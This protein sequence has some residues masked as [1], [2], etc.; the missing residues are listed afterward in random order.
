MSGQTRPEERPHEA[1]PPEVVTALGAVPTVQQWNAISHPLS[2]C[3]VIAGAGSG[4]TAVM[5]ARLVYL[6]LVRL[7]RLEDDHDGA[8]PSEVLCLTFTNKAAEEL[9]R[10]VRDATA[11]LDLPEGEEATV[12]TYHAFASRLLDEYGLRMGLERSLRLL[13]EAQRWQLC[14]SLLDE[15]EFEHLE[16]RTDY[17]V[18]VAL[19][20]ADQCANHLRDPQEVVDLDRALVQR[21]EVER[22]TG[23]DAKLLSAAQRRMEAAALAQA[24]QDRKREIGAIDYGD[25]IRLAYDLIEKHPEVAEAFRARFPVLLLDE[26]QDTNVAQARLL[27]SLCGRGY[28]VFAVG[29]PDQNIYAW[30]GASLANLLRF[31]HD[32][33][34]PDQGRELPLYVNFRSGSRILD[35]ANLVIEPVPPERRAADKEL[36]P[37]ES[38][39]EGRVAAF[40]AEDAYAEGRRIAAIIQEEAQGT[41]TEE[42]H[43]DYSRFAILCRKSRLFEPISEVLREEGIPVEVVDLGGLLRIP[44]VVEVV[45]WLRLLEDPGYNVGFTRILTGPRWRIGYRDLAAL[46]RWSAERTR[47]LR[48]EL[49]GDDDMPGDVVFA[50]VEALDHLDDE[51]MIGLSE[52]ARGR[53]REFRGVLGRVQ[54]GAGGTLGDLLS[55]I[56]EESGLLAELESSR[57]PAAL[58]ARRNLLN[59]VQHVSSFAPVEGQATLST[60]IEYFRTA[61]EVEDDLERAQPSEA[62]TVKMLTIHKAKGLEWDVVFVPGLAEHDRYAS[63]IFPDTSR[64]ANPATQYGTMPFELR[65]DAEVLPRYEGDIRGFRDAL[66]ER[67]MEEERRLCYVAFTRA[68]QL[69]VASAAHWYP[70]PREPHRPGTFHEHVASYAMTEVLG[71]A[72]PPGESPLVELRRRRAGDWPQPARSDDGDGLL[73]EGWHEAA[74]AAV[75]DP[76]WADR[77]A[78]ALGPGDRRTFERRVAADT[79]RAALIRRQTEVRDV[80]AL[81]SSLSVSSV[82]DYLRCPKLFYW[83]QVR[84]LPRRPSQAARL[85]T[86]VHRWI[87]IQSKGQLALLDVDAL[88]DLTMEER[89]SEPGEAERMRRAFR[90]SRFADR[91]PLHTE[92]PFLLYLDGVVVGGRIDAIFGEPEGHWEIVDYKTGRLPAD[93]DPL[94]GMQ[95]DIYGLACAEVWGK[96]PEDLTLTYFYLSEGKEVTRAAGPVHEV[97]DRLLEAI[98]RAAAGEFGATPGPQCRWCDF[99]SFCEPGRSYLRD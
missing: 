58:G 75:A 32:F 29:D 53:L 9:F 59:L 25:Q 96:R 65:G 47:S 84:P 40:T 4:K 87:E 31:L 10:R 46:A 98:G 14:R 12:L 44:E 8:L 23:D 63:S 24:F 48:E 83:S 70:G 64:Q 69:L 68:R 41:R 39:G 6:A 45:A 80:E 13:S 82:I 38:R 43:P 67:G 72:E 71:V 30:R 90:A 20:L 3:A 66:T 74:L 52:A 85:G 11:G 86:E 16:I 5:A 88:P 21:R 97:R 54:A 42:G 27:Q 36:R 34:E 99:L 60:L 61:E 7:G 62:N 17:V 89:E 33:G 93:D 51:R 77:R 81:P 49:P 26:F 18:G 57:N 55:V 28:P 35:V 94:S 1:A 15:M 56:V 37:H 95:L 22:A 50:L 73:P 91:V 76:G 19:G 78:E 92:R 79:E 2:P